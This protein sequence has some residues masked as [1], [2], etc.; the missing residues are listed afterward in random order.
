MRTLHSTP[1]KKDRDT[2]SATPMKEWRQDTPSSTLNE[3]GRRILHQKR[4]MGTPSPP[5]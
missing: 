4:R 5:T 2:F 1:K 3:R